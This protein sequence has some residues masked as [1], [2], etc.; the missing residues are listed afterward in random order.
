MLF[1]LNKLLVVKCELLLISSEF[2]LVIVSII[3][4]VLEMI[5][6]EVCVYF[7][8]VVFFFIIN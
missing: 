8:W 6:F 3:C 2:D 7:G 4:G 5:C 1:E